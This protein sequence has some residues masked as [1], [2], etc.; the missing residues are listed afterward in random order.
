M[1]LINDFEVIL[2]ER[3]IELCKEPKGLRFIVQY[4]YNTAN[5]LRILL[6]TYKNEGSYKKSNMVLLDSLHII[7]M[8]SK[9]IKRKVSLSHWS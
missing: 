8:N 6:I 2:N 1:K 9:S 5:V 7:I 3:S 4:N